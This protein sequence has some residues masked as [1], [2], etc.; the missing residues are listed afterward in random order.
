[1]GV[2][3]IDGSTV[4]SFVNDDAQ[5]QKSIDE[6]FKSLDLNKDGVLSRLELRRAFES[7]RLI[8][9]DFGKEILI[10]VFLFSVT[11]RFVC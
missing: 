1:M 10:S 7:L 8:D 4:R 9:T 3:I 11:C 5:F 6:A 2:V